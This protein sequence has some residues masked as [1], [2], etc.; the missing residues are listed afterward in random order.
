MYPP[1]LHA[2]TATIDG[3]SIDVLLVGDDVY[4]YKIPLTDIENAPDRFSM[5]MIILQAIRVLEDNW[6][7]NHGNGQKIK[8]EMVEP[9]IEHFVFAGK[10]WYVM[11]WL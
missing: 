7:K 6:N 3:L 10:S 1:M 2:S 5:Q 8:I 4:R 11:G 9:T